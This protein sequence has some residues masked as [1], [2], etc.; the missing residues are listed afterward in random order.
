MFNI[1]VLVSNGFD[2]V[3]ACD[4]SK[5]LSLKNVDIYWLMVCTFKK[6]EFMIAKVIDNLHEF[7][8]FLFD[9]F[10]FI[11]VLLI[12]HVNPFFN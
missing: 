8:S 11:T 6:I 3:P 4:S 7:E 9:A 12:S 5:I 2:K 1:Y 10:T